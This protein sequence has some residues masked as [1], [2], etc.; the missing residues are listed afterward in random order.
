MSK[1]VHTLPTH[2][3]KERSGIQIKVVDFGIFG[4]NRGTFVEKS[5]AGSLKYMAPEILQGRTGSTPAIDV[6]SMG[7][8]FYS[9]IFGEYPFA[10][11]NREELKS[12]ILTKEIKVRRND[13]LRFDKS[14]PLRKLKRRATMANVVS[15]KGKVLTN[16]FVQP[17]SP[18]MVPKTKQ[19]T[20]IKIP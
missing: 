7:C 11:H 2:D 10:S 17:N 4:S 1:P 19:L 16:E 20:S 5:T 18:S 8:I 9:L 13:N 12:Q 3:S 6:W 15:V 14:D